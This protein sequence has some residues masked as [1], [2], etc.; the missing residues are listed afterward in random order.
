MPNRS[1]GEINQLPILISSMGYSRTDMG[2]K[3]LA[4]LLSRSRAPLVTCQVHLVQ[5]SSAGIA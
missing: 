1:S 4:A 3:G 2:S 5:W